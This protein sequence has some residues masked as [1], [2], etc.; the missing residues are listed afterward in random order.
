MGISSSRRSSNTWAERERSR[1][2]G[3]TPTVFRDENLLLQEVI[4]FAVYRRNSVSK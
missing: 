4:L 3:A 1:M 2:A